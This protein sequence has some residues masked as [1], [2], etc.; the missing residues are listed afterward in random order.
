MSSAKHNSGRKSKFSERDR[1]TLHRI[2]RKDCRTTAHKIT[3]ELT[4]Y[5]QNPVSTKTVRW[6]FYKWTLQ[7]RVAFRKSLISQ[8]N[9]LKLLEWCMTYWNWS[10]KQWKRVILSD[11]S[12]FSLFL[13][14][15]RVYVWRQPKEAFLSD[16]L[17]LTIET[18]SG[19]LFLGN[20]Q[21]Q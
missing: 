11:E 12:S 2:F 19:V 6:E 18:W 9:V 14:T 7:G 15:S 13:T 20:P 10:L 1:R 3:S 17:Q 4:E 8:T 21:S 5:L 16:C